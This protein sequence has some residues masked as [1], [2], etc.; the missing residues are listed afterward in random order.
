MLICFP[1][2]KIECAEDGGTRSII[3]VEHL[4]RTRITSMLLLAAELLFEGPSSSTLEAMNKPKRGP[5]KSDE[6]FNSS[7]FFGDPGS[8]IFYFLFSDFIF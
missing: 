8:F 7:M 5:E 3:G 2:N 6:A 1:E 4:T